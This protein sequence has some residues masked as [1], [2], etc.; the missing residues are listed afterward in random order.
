MGRKLFAAGVAAGLLALGGAATASATVS[1]SYNSSSKQLT[2][3]STG[4]EEGIA[5]RQQGQNIL[6]TNDVMMKPLGCSGGSPT[7]TNTDSIHMTGAGTSPFVYFDL[8]K[9]Y[10][11]PGVEV[12]SDDPEI[13]L[14][15]E[16]TDGFFGMGG[17][18]GPDEFR[19]GHTLGN[20]GK[21]DGDADPDFTLG[22]SQ[23]VL[24]RGGRGKDVISGRGGGTLANPLDIPMN[25]QGE[26]GGDKLTGGDD[27]DFIDG[28]GGKDKISAGA[29]K[30]EIFVT[31]GGRDKVKCGDDKD[32]VEADASDK[33][34]GDCEKVK[35]S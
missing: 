4:F 7:V 34:A 12:E 13:E 14:V 27:I 32:K 11:A 17:S 16:W 26:A 21:V 23:N 29:G 10:L 9:G 18:N 31:G 8:R 33:I 1:C 19:F 3:T 2:L 30:D 20:L 25:I 28:G 6:V 24:V 15:T 22:S 5:V 35:V